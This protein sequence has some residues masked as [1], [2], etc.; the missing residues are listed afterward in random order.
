ME[1]SESMNLNYDFYKIQGQSAIPKKGK[2]LI[3]EPFL[4]DTHFKRSIVLL[5]EHNKE[6]SV[7]FVLN[8]PVDLAVSDIL[9]DFPELAADIS[10]GGP[11]GTNT[12]HYLHTLGNAVPNS[13][14]VMKNIYWGG[15]FNAIK[16]LAGAGA[17]GSQQLRFF[18]GYSGWRPNQLEEELAQ[19]AWAVEDI[20]AWKVM[21]YTEESSWKATLEELGDKY[22]MWLLTPE[23]PNLN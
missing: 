23:T 6:G 15:D 16:S 1:K 5:T 11:V 17:I 7:G 21:N 9:E 22:K 10:M 2:I 19:N 14:R 4:N 18:L 13:V 20:E 8:K 12:V 3:A